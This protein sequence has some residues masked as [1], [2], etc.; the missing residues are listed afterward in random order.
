[1]TKPAIELLNLLTIF[2]RLSSATTTATWQSQNIESHPPSCDFPS[3]IW[4]NNNSNNDDSDMAKS[5]LFNLPHPLVMFLDLSYNKNNNDNDNSSTTKSE[6]LNL[7]HPLMIFLHLSYTTTTT[8]TATWHSQN[9]WI[10][11][12]L[13]WFAF[14]YFTQQQQHVS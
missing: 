6:P 8:T 1:M 7:P 13:L 5:E 11:L 12:A 2:L 10:S 9:Y 14:I 3:S 4:H